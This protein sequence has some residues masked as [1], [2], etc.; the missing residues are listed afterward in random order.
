M[1]FFRRLAQQLREVWAGMSAARRTLVLAVTVGVVALIAGLYYYRT[2]PEWAVLYSHLS[3]DETQ[4]IRDKLQTQGIPVRV[5]FDGSTVEVPADRVGA[6]RI[7]LASQGLPAQ[8][9]GYEL[10]D[11]PSLGSTPF[12]QNVN[13]LRAKQAVIAKTIRQLEPVANATVE[14]AKPEPSPF[15][16]EK[17]PTTASVMVQLKPNAT[18]SRAQVSGIVAF[19]SKAV[20]GLTAENVTVVDSKGNQLSEPSGPEVGQ[21][22]SQLDY[23]RAVE[24]YLAEKAQAILIPAL[25]AGRAVVKVTA[26][27]N[28]QKLKEV[29]DTINPEQKALKTEKTT[30]STSQSTGGGAR[31]VA[32]AA[33]NLAL[34]QP[35][36]ALAAGGGGTSLSKEEQSEATYD[37]SRTHL[38]MEDKLGNLNRL[39]VA[40]TVDLTAPDGG[41]PP[42]TKQA[43]EGLIKEALGF[44][45]ARGDTIQVA[46][47]K[48]VAAAPPPPKE[49]EPPA[50]KEKEWW[51]NPEFFMYLRNAS[52]AM[53]VLLL[54]LVMVLIAFLLLR[55]TR[56]PAAAGPGREGAAERLATAAQR[57]PE[58]LA[59]AIAALMEQP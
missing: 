21:V 53:A 59:R 13:L 50:E 49:P 39:T 15:I 17:Q 23:R 47:A 28:F 40:A 45:E 36:A 1:D 43:V 12:V 8:A 55:R 31:G 33:S 22:A 11:E 27:I 16:R 9:K 48:L 20:E 26:D 38:E 7:D 18:L 44:D 6:V 29:R 2:Q 51:R 14:I 24:S 3:Q 42:L 4:A 41:K 32:G 57:D 30:T 25:G 5:S 56:P 10:F 46:E 52:L 37:Y 35:N 19:V 58:A 34:R 54:V